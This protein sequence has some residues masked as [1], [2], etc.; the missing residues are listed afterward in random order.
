MDEFNWSW[1]SEV[2]PFA[3]DFHVK[4]RRE[5]VSLKLHEAVQKFGN[6]KVSEEIKRFN[7]WIGDLAVNVER[8]A[9]KIEAAM[10]GFELTLSQR[11][12]QLEDLKAWQK[13]N[14]PNWKDPA[15]K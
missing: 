13:V 14:D 9:R 11:L 10:L 5:A 3:L 8:E 6:Q 4:K 12:G 1:E 15:D 7:K 2:L